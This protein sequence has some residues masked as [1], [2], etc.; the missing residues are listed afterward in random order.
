[1]TRPDSL[2]RH[3]DEVMVYDA[4]GIYEFRGVIVGVHHCDPALYDIQPPGGFTLGSRR[5]GVP[6]KQLRSVSGPIRAYEPR[7]ADARH[8][9]DEA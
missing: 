6:E 2:R 3:G 1:M 8:I 5:C 4:K 9:R 7:N